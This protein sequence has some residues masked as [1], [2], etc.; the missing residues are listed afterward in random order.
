MRSHRRRVEK[1]TL[2]MSATSL[3]GISSPLS[4]A[5][6]VTA[7]HASYSYLHMS[8]TLRISK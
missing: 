8:T 2:R 6:L 4:L 7:M 5:V 1:L 3:I